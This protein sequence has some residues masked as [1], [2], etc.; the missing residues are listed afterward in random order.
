MRAAAF[1][2]SILSHPYAWLWLVGA[3][4]LGAYGSLVWDGISAYRVAPPQLLAFGAAY[5]PAL[6]A[7]EYWRLLIT[8]WL[9]GTLVHTQYSI[10]MLGLLGPVAVRH[11]GSGA[12]CGAF[13]FGVAAGIGFSL[14]VHGDQ[15]MI[16][17]GWGGLSTLGG[18]VL[19]YTFIR[20][21]PGW[22]AGLA[23]LH[24]LL[25]SLYA[26]VA[27]Q[28]AQIGFLPQIGCF[29]L[30]V[31][32]GYILLRLPARQGL[33]NAHWALIAFLCGFPLIAALEYMQ[34]SGRWPAERTAF[35]AL[36]RFEVGLISAG[37]DI[38][39]IVISR[40]RSERKEQEK[41]LR[42]ELDGLQAELNHLSAVARET[43]PGRVH[44]RLVAAQGVIQ[45][46]IATSYIYRMTGLTPNPVVRKM[47][48]N[49]EQNQ[50]LARQRYRTTFALGM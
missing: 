43:P 12:S 36:Y 1:F 48:S 20:H 29:L 16:V 49:M 27:R 50:R 6:E 44:N 31:A 40:G 23:F 4:W 35:E 34:E 26:L 32:V 11:Y 47:W 18:M 39:D 22:V 24:L 46:L 33:L 5:A 13:V 10:V 7:G 2:Q 21:I 37:F 14:L 30:G 28:L 17:G 9:H 19:A 45:V 25:V 38:D 42:L 8:P 15:Y 3:I 41:L